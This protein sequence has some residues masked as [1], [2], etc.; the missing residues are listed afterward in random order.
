MA[1]ESSWCIVGE[2]EP[3]KNYLKHGC[4]LWDGQGI[5]SDIVQE[6]QQKVGNISFF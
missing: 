5:F 2:E 3:T 6:S 1:T 4:H